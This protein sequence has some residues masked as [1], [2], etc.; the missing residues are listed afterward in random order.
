MRKFLRKGE[1]EIANVDANTAIEEAIN[2]LHGDALL[3]DIRIE[4]EFSG[5]LPPIAADIVQF[6]QVVMNIARNGMEAMRE[7]RAI[8]GGLLVIRT[9][10]AERGEVRIDIEDSG[11]D[12]SNVPLSEVLDPFVTTKPGG[13]GL[14]LS[15]CRTIVEAHGGRLWIE[16]SSSDGTTVSFAMRLST[17][18]DHGLT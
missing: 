10:L 3:R 4:Y 14:G 8:D 6:Q 7:A 9:S 17:R 15:I 5:A 18:T 13:L 2:L 12:I 16:E 11:P 1:T